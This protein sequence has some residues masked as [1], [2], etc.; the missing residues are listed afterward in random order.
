MWAPGP[1]LGPIA[2]ISG[3]PVDK[4]SATESSSLMNLEHE[5]REMM[6]GQ[7]DAVQ[8]ISRPGGRHDGSLWARECVS[9]FLCVSAAARAPE[10]GEG[11]WRATSPRWQWW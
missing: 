2:A 6:V 8:A 1:A 4:V 10:R 9:V 11:D 3:V 7:V 5:M